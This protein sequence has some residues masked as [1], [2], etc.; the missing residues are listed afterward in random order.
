MTD[1]VL[2][3]KPLRPE[4]LE[5]LEARE[6][7]E[8]VRLDAPTPEAIDERI[9]GIDAICIKNTPLTEA[10]LERATR[11]RVIAKHGVGLDN[12]PMAALTRRGIPVLSVGDANATSVAEHALMLMLGL[13]RRVGHYDARARA[14][15]YITDPAWP[16]HEL[17]GATLLLV[18]LGRIG[19]RVARLARAFDM[20]V[21]AFDPWA[22]DE[23]L[24]RAGVRRETDLDAALGRAD[25]VSLHCPLT[26]DT[27]HLMNADRLSRVKP[28]AFLINTARGELVDEA[29]LLAALPADPDGAGADASVPA[30][31]TGLAGAGLDVFEVEPPDPANPLFANPCVLVSPHSAAL[32][33]E[34]AIRMARLTAANALAGLDGSYDPRYLANPEIDR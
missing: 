1:T 23:A 22:P 3:L 10:A 31:P 26:E 17:A 4:G 18:G 9:E 11:L 28:G 24:A 15:G 20:D 13:A 19:E 16:T 12:L 33:V 34:T 27:R 14:G 30:A 8:V 5:L 2:V 7:L 21:A 29:A 32:S 25:H 6:G